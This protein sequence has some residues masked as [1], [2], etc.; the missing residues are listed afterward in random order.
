MKNT[1]ATVAVLLAF[2]GAAHATETGCTAETLQAKA[3]EA[4]TA[5]QSLAATNPSLMQEIV[6]D[7]QT[8]QTEAA[9]V[10]DGDF[11]ALCDAY[12]TILTKMQ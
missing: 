10:T 1:I 8:V 4:A 6:A 11:S 5:M 2:G 9:T 7:L 3:M 12:D